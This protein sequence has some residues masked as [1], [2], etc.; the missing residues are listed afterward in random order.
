M[1]KEYS[2]TPSAVMSRNWR[3]KNKEK[4]TKYLREWHKKRKE[5]PDEVKKR[6]EVTKEWRANNRDHVNAYARNWSKTKESEETKKYRKQQS[7]EWDKKGLRKGYRA[8]KFGLT[9]EEYNEHMNREKCAIEGCNNR[10][11]ALDHNHKTGQVRE[12]LCRQCNLAY[13]LLE[14]SREKILGLLKY[15]DKWYSVINEEVNNGH[16]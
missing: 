6:V 2:Q 4:I 10:P 11:K 13:G 5:D 7:K 16:C 15:H 9:L 8:R 1:K 3:E 12:A 14:E